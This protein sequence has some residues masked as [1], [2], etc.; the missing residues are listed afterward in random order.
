MSLM[1]KRSDAFCNTVNYHK[2]WDTN[3]LKI[4]SLNTVSLKEAV[5]KVDCQEQGFLDAVEIVV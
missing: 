4:R 3:E 5:D 2:S 1:F